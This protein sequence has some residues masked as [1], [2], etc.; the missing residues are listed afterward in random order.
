MPKD[1]SPSTG[2]IA[3]CVKKAY[4][5]FNEGVLPN[6]SDHKKSRRFCHRRNSKDF[7]FPFGKTP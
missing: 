2:E 7:D 1:L 4:G 6:T 3:R 5:F